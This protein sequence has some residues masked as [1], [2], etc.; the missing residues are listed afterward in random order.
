M[1]LT[2][3]HRFEGDG[4][5]FTG[6]LALMRAFMG[7]V[8]KACPAAPALEM[9]FFHKDVSHGLGCMT[10][11]G[12]GIMRED[13]ALAIVTGV[14]ISEMEASSFFIQLFRQ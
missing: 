13:F 8:G 6:V 9:K 2:F 3:V 10:G 1:L 4:T 12:T 7:T 11:N 14:G 5:A